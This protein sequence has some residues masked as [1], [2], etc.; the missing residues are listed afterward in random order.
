M[1]S[2]A[3]RKN[4]EVLWL[5]LD[6]TSVPVMM[7]NTRGTIKKVFKKIR[8]RYPITIR[9]SLQDARACFTYVAIICNVPEIQALLPQVI[10]VSDKQCSWDRMEEIWADLP[11]NIFVK[12]KSS[13]WTDQ[14]H[15]RVI[16]K[17]LGRVLE[18]YLEQYQAILIFDALKA[19]LVEDVL[20]ELFI[21]L[22]WYLVVP[23]DLTYLL[24]P[25]DAHVFSFFK[26]RLRR[27]FNHSLTD[28]TVT[29]KTMKQVRNC[30]Q[31]I[32]EFLSCTDWSHA[33]NLCGYGDD[34]A[35][36]TSKPFQHALEWEQNFPQIA[37]ERPAEDDMKRLCW[38]ADMPFEAFTAYLPFPAAK[39]AAKAEP[40]PP[41][42]VLPKLPAPPL[43]A[44][45]PTVKAALHPPAKPPA[46]RPKLFPPS[47]PASKSSGACMSLPQV[48]KQPQPPPSA[49]AWS[50]PLAT[51]SHPVKMQPAASPSSSSSTVPKPKG[52]LL[53]PLDRAGHQMNA[54]TRRY[55]KA[56]EMCRT[57][58]PAADD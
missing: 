37:T 11:N 34:P 9:G 57:I 8:W 23:K 35:N 6:E 24:Q 12:R 39:A 36:Q 19:H 46:A 22:M 51:A 3:R 5:N 55:M 45:P 50:G 53:L 27:K 17:I 33:F 20:E 56:Q 2:E 54:E 25:L 52:L 47:P 15:H 7:L 44:L 28:G 41:E 16:I 40:P 30:I 49:H 32:T 29:S 14:E 48:T 10:F 31:V 43:L 26:K 58:N 4:K 42:Q 21:W 38:P 13:A 1:R 18:P